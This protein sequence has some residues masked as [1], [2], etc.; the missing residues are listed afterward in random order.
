MDFIIP[1][2]RELDIW[3]QF[4]ND[5]DEEEEIPFVEVPPNLYELYPPAD[6]TNICIVCRVEQRTHALVSCGHKVLC[7]D[8]VTQLQAQRCPLCNNNFIMELRIW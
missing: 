8:C 5:T 7:V 2:D 4:W 3:Q 1:E 6:E